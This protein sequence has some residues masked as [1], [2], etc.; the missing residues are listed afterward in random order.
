MRALALLAC[1]LLTGCGIQRIWTK[2]EPADASVPAE[3]YVQCVDLDA[4]GDAVLDWAPWTDGS[5]D[6]LR[7]VCEWDKRL[8]AKLA[9]RCEAQRYACAAALQRLRTAG[10]IK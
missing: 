3:C 8:A 4:Q 9:G 1:F 10:A 6:Q 2:P 5:A 7:A